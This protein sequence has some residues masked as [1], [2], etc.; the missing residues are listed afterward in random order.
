[1]R[2]VIK[3]LNTVRVTMKNTQVWFPVAH[4]NAVV[5]DGTRQVVFVLEPA[6][7]RVL[8]GVHEAMR[9]VGF[10]LGVHFTLLGSRALTDSPVVD[11]P[12]CTLAAAV[13]ALT[14]LF[15]PPRDQDTL[16]ALVVWVHD[17]Q[18]WLIR[19]LVRF[20]ATP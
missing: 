7:H 11:L 8:P 3:H 20:F 13:Q 18:H 1:M 19:V 9:R 16:D 6:L 14:V 12:V 4:A 15:N 2:V 10:A 17:H 5:V